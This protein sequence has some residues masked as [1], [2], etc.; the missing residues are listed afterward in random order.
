MIC[1]I[2]P[3][4][5]LNRTHLDDNS[6][7][8][9]TRVF[10]QSLAQVCSRELCATSGSS[11]PLAKL[12]VAAPLL[13]RCVMEQIDAQVSDLR[14]LSSG[15]LALSSHDPTVT[16]GSVP[17]YGS[18]AHAAATPP[19]ILSPGSAS[20]GDNSAHPGASA[21]GSAVATPLAGGSK[22]KS[23]DDANSSGKQTRSKRNRVS[24]NFSMQLLGSRLPRLC[25]GRQLLFR[26]FDAFF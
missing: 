20:L 11:P 9:H 12:L 18:H 3:I 8:S 24:G 6:L 13:L 21:Q 10:E 2:S 25:D 14:Y 5:P 19:P 7:W 4:I 16:P 1:C 26:Y 15:P 23:D 22:R 17:S